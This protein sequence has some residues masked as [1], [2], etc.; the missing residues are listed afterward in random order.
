[1][2]EISDID[3]LLSV[4]LCDECCNDLSDHGDGTEED[5][6]KRL[7]RIIAFLSRAEGESGDELDANARWLTDVIREVRKHGRFPL[8][9]HDMPRLREVREAMHQNAEQAERIAEL[10]GEVE[11]QS[12]QY[13]RMVD[14]RF[15]ELL[16]VHKTLGGADYQGTAE[17][18]GIRMKELAELQAEVERLRSWAAE[19]V[20]LLSASAN[21]SNV[22][23]CIDKLPPLSHKG[24][25]Q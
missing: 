13:N 22:Q 20:I 10:E 16:L 11:R 3:W 21:Y 1:M 17:I 25:E 23:E 2:S 14:E 24:G 18:A 12:V 19:A 6:K 5:T 8:S 4:C 9:S 7:T 15:G